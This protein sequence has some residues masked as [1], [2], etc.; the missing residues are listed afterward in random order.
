LA[1]LTGRQ[2][3]VDV[4]GGTSLFGGRGGVV[5]T[6]LGALIISVVANGLVLLN[7]KPFWTQAVQGVIILLAVLADRIK[8]TSWYE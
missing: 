2:P 6:L 3:D 4:I 5:G 8:C 1:R 7:V